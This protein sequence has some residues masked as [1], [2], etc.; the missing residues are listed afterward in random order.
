MVVFPDSR[1]DCHDLSGDPAAPGQ[2][3]AP[4]RISEVL[5][6][7]WRDFA[8]ASDPRAF[9]TR[10]SKNWRARTVRVRPELVQVFTN[11]SASRVSWASVVSISIR[12]VF[13]HISDSI[14][15]ADDDEELPGTGKRRQGAHGLCYSAERHWLKNLVLLGV[16]SAWLVRAAV[17]VTLRVRLPIVAATTAWRTCRRRGR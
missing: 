10:K 2:A 8:Y 1:H 16:V 14:A 6:F 5:E 7:E 17:H 12:T 11:W 3:G 15:W 13:R 4:Q 9:L